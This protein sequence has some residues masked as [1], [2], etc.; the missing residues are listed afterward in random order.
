MNR[1]GR[2]WVRRVTLSTLDDFRSLLRTGTEQ[3]AETQISEEANHDWA[4]VDSP[5][6]PEANVEEPKITDTSALFDGIPINVPSQH[7][8][9]PQDTTI[10]P[11]DPPTSPS[12]ITPQPPAVPAETFS[13]VERRWFKKMSAADAQRPKSQNTNPTGHLT[14]VKSNHPI[15]SGTWFRNNLFDGEDWRPLPSHQGGRE[16]ATII[17]HVWIADSYLGEIDLNVTYTPSFEAGQGNRTT[18]LH[19]GKT[20]GDYFKQVDYAGHYVTIERVS[21]RT[22]QLVIGSSHPGDFVG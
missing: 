4:T 12:S 6:F 5:V 10:P 8:S 19:W 14:L 16:R 15:H 3:A 9:H 17:F 22:F 18:V 21:T 2:G 7:R 1:P 11:S 13:T 20:I